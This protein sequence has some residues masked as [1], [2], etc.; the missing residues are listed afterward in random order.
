MKL[1]WVVSE[2][3][4]GIEVDQKKLRYDLRWH[5]ERYFFILLADG[6]ASLCIRTCDATGEDVQMHIIDGLSLS[7][8][9]SLYSIFAYLID[10]AMSKRNNQ[11]RGVIQMGEFPL[12]S[13]L[14]QTISKMPD[15]VDWI[16]NTIITKKRNLVINYANT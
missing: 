2:M 7:D 3:R 12:T 8:D 13:N 10:D 1:A 11:K 9:G 6:R 15:L 16:M 4:I 5:P 14:I